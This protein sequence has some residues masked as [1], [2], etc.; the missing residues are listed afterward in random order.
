MELLNTTAIIGHNSGAVIRLKKNGEPRKS[1]GGRIAG[2]TTANVIINIGTLKGLKK[3]TRVAPNLWLYVRGASRSWVY[4]KMWNGNPMYLG[5]GAFPAVSLVDA[6]K[7]VEEH[8]AKLAKGEDPRTQPVVHRF[9]DVVP[10]WVEK[11]SPEWTNA[12]Y[13]GD[14]VKEIDRY[15]MDHLGDMDVEKIETADVR[16]CLMQEVGT[17]DLPFWLH[18][19]KTAYR[20]K[21]FIRE[22]I[23]Y[24]MAMKWRKLGSGN[25]GA[26]EDNLCHVLAD[27]K[28]IHAPKPHASVHHSEIAGFM[29]VLRAMKGMEFRCLELL[30][31][32]AVRTNEAIGTRWPEI[33]LTEATWT[34]P[35]ERMKK[36][37]AHTVPLSKRAVA[38]L[39]ALP[40][41]KSD[42]VFGELG[43]E[44]LRDATAAVMEKAGRVWKDKQTGEVATPH[45][46]RA[47]FGTWGGAT[48]VD[49]A[50][51]DLCLAHTVGSDV[52]RRY[53]RSDKADLRRKVMQDW[54]D[55]LAS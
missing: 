9:R 17:E 6:K 39:K 52:L 11:Q 13:A 4:V 3:N 27:S 32:T 34:I 20:V 29:K 2:Q 55:H 49:D 19:H 24:A 14:V 38:L 43:T 25:P 47:S 30:I 46:F 37:K 54:S 36:R 18:R 8:N 48:G 22:V 28:K 23:G 51:V 44:A 15:V 35:G 31:E 33:D 16:D 12:K 53:Q 5:L 26:W 50:L 41:G 21:G 7:K 40:R 45:G 1:N 10:L 42:L